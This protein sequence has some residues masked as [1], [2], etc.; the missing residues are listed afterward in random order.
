MLGV[1]NQTFFTV[2]DVSAGEFIKAYAEFLKKNNK[3]EVPK[4]T[5]FVKTA[6]SKELAPL[7]DDWLYVKVAAVARKIYLRG[8][9]GVG[10]MQHIFGKKQR[11][12]VVRNHHSHAS[13]K[14]IRFSLQQLEKS[15]LVPSK[16]VENL[17]FSLDLLRYESEDN[18]RDQYFLSG[19]GT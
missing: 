3:V 14:L 17:K 5:E 6:K 11:N 15:N 10:A 1:Q 9:L 2:K 19:E 12:G 18:L 7:D 4:W 16:N 13:G 8:H